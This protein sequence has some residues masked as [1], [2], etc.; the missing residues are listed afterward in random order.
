MI[1]ELQLLGMSMYEARVFNSLA[2]GKKN[3]RELSKNSD[4]PF[5]KVYS[6]IKTLKDKGFVLETNSRPKLVYVKN[7]SEVISDLIEKRKR[8]EFELFDRIRK[9]AAD[10]NKEK[11]IEGGFFEIGTTLEDNKK[12]QMRT[13]TESKDEVLQILNVHHDPKSNR[14]NKTIWENEIVKAVKRGIK[15]KA[16][17]PAGAELPII[18]KKLN[19]TRPQDFQVRRIN[20]DLPRIDIIDGKKCLIK[21]VH[22]DKVNFG[23]VIFVEN[24]KLAENLMRIFYSIWD[25]AE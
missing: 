3:L 23:G 14:Q 19:S 4:V 20:T 10:F 7:P 21:I 5:G 11:D 16:I 6:I 22:A 13:F 18:L 8:E 12:V 24:E 9:K 25:I 15:F 17:Y 1:K 2:N